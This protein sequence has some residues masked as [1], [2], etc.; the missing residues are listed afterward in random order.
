ML[1]PEANACKGSMVAP[2]IAAVLWQEERVVDA[3]S[4]PER[5]A[6]FV[7]LKHAPEDWAVLKI[8]GVVRV[9]TDEEKSCR[10]RLCALI[11]FPRE[12]LV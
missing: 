5:D 3:C 7:I 12:Q 9:E 11:W 6:V 10:R 2:T 1:R 4:S 8:W